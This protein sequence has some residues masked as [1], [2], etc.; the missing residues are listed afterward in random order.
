MEITLCHIGPIG[1]F[2]PLVTH[3]VQRFPVN[4]IEMLIRCHGAIGHMVPLLWIPVYLY[5]GDSFKGTVSVFMCHVL[6]YSY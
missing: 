3:L 6:N 5:E 1:L 2:T 4:F